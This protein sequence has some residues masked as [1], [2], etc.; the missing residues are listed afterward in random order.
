MLLAHFIFAA[1]FSLSNYSYAESV[2]HTERYELARTFVEEL[3]GMHQAEVLMNRDLKA[4]PQ[5]SDRTQATMI[6]IV[7]N[8]T[9]TRMRLNVT[10][11]LLQQIEPVDKNFESLI[12]YLINMYGRKEQLYAE[13][14]DAGKTMLAGE[15]PGVDYGV[16][17]GRM[18]EVRAQLE[19]V[20]ESIFKAVPMLGM[21]MVSDKPDSKGHLSHFAITRK[22]AQ[23]IISMIQIGFGK[24]L[25]AKEQNWTTSSA[26]ILRTYLR[27][28]GFK[29]SD[30]PWQ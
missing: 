5:N 8:G 10:I 13:M 7:R 14:V 6:A 26:S 15:K 1:V 25:D 27:D 28:K 11:R 12:S 30:D 20:D 19:F 23:E 2:A 3:V 16:L 9:R 29:Y 18:P 21:L 17:V 22:E 24:S 4:I